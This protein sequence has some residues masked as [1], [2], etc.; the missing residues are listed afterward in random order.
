MICLFHTEFTIPKRICMLLQK[1]KVASALIRITEPT[2]QMIGSGASN[3][4]A[5]D[6]NLVRLKCGVDCGLQH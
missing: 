4:Y 2:K 5:H 1:L 6:L 3:K